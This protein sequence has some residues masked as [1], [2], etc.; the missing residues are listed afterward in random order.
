MVPSIKSHRKNIV[1]D[2]GI[3][4]RII[5]ALAAI[6][7]MGRY[8]HFKMIKILRS[9]KRPNVIS[10]RHIW[11]F[12]LENFP[13]TEYFVTQKNEYDTKFDDIFIM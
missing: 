9:M 6:K 8:K 3:R 12:L 10:N 5:R 4:I 1:V 11:N 7:P 2:N 13:E